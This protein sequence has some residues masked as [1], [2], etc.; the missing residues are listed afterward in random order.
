[1]LS[2]TTMTTVLPVKDMDRARAFYQDSL[3]L[4]PAGSNGDD[5]MMFSSGGSNAVELIVRPDADTSDHTSVS[6]EVADLESEMSDLAGKGI[7]FADYDLPGLKTENHIA[8]SEHQR[9]AWFPD[10]EGNILCLHQ[11]I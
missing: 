6:F 11:N 10:S 5:S 7:H 4:K 9:C 3:G 8:V 1:M 2:T